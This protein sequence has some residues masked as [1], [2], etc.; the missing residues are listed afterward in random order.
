MN[1]FLTCINRE[2]DLWSFKADLSADEFG[3]EPPLRSRIFQSTISQNSHLTPKPDGILKRLTSQFN[4]YAN[5]DL[6]ELN[7]GRFRNTDSGLRTLNNQRINRLSPDMLKQ[8]SSVT[9]R[10][11]STLVSN[12]QQFARRHSD[13]RG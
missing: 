5:Q 2:D 3:K 8:I 13:I 10:I 12:E 7:I 6:V 4:S 9:P 11:E 1:I